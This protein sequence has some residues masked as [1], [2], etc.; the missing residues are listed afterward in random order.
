MCV[1]RS[2]CSHAVYV[3]ACI[4]AFAIFV[5]SSRG[6]CWILQNGGLRYA[7]FGCH[8]WLTVPSVD[9]C[10]VVVSLQLWLNEGFATWA[11]WLAVDDKFPEWQTWDQFVST[12]AARALTTDAMLSS[13]PIEIPIDNPDMIDQVSSAFVRGLT[14]V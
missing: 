2:V 13:H 11:G 4:V 14:S 9:V 10:V 7:L 1:Y 5:F 12:E 8:I 6:V 3:F